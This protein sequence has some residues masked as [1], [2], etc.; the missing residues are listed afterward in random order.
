VS[1]HLEPGTRGFLDDEADVILGVDVR[2]IVDDDLDD[3]RAEVRVLPNG[4]LHLVARVREEILG[5]AEPRL[6]RLELKLPAVRGDDPS[7]GNHRRSGDQAGL[8]P[9]A[10]ARARIV[11]FVAD[12]AHAREAGFEHR[13]CVRD[14]L[15]RP[16]AVWIAQRGQKVAGRVTFQIDV[17]A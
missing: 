10:H 17:H 12:I 8:D 7:G 14:T 15:H 9:G 4:L 1:R 5:L 6:I 2:L 3:C 13:P 11:P 16:V